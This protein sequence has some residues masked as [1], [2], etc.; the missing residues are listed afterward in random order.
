[1][2][3]NGKPNP[4]YHVELFDS[5]TTRH[6]SPYRE[7]FESITPIPSKPFTAANQTF[8][9]TDV[10]D[11][12]IEVPNCYDSKL[13]LTKVSYSPEAAYRRLHWPS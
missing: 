4:T 11:M 1:M 8:S 7:R 13:R 2:E 6:T 12:V 3:A 9:A 5:G 10:G